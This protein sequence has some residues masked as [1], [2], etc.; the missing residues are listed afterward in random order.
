M[1]RTVVVPRRGAAVGRVACAHH[2]A[3]EEEV[4]GTIPSAVDPGG[5]AAQPGLTVRIRRKPLR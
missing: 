2:T 5:K 3:D 4:H 1:R